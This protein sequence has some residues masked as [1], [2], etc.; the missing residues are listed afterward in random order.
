MSNPCNFGR[1]TDAR[2]TSL[3]VKS[4]TAIDE[5]C[6]FKGKGANFKELNVRD[7]ATI[8]GDLTIKGNLC[9]DNGC[10]SSGVICETQ[11]DFCC[12]A[13]YVIVGAGAAGSVL[14]GRLAE[15]GYSVYLIEAG[16]DTSPTSKDLDAQPDL[17]NIQVPLNFLNLYNR[18]NEI[19]PAGN[20]DGQW[21]ATSTLLDFV[22]IDQGNVPY[23]SYPRGAGAGGSVSHHALQDGVGSLKVYD[24]L[25]EETGDDFWR[26]SN[27][28]RLF[29][30]M[31]D[32][33]AVP[34]NPGPIFAGQ[35]GWLKLSQGTIEPI[36]ANIIEVVTAPPFNVPFRE[37]FKNPANVSGIGNADIQVNPQGLR[38]QPYDGFLVPIQQTTGR[39]ITKFNHLASKLLLTENCDGGYKCTGV[40]AFD[41]RFAQEI[42]TGGATFGNI[43]GS[44]TVIPSDKTKPAKYTKFYAKKEVIV[45]GGAIQSP[46]LLMLSGIGP[47]DHLD[48]VGIE[49]KVD[50][51]GVGSNLTDHCEFSAIFE[52]DPTKYIHGWQAALLLGDNNGDDI[53]DPNI[54]AVAQASADAGQFNE[55][56]G[57]IAWDWHS[58]FEAIDPLFPDTHSIPYATFFWTFDN[59]LLPNTPLDP[60]HPSEHNDHNRRTLLP[61]PSNPTSTTAGPNNK[62]VL[63]SSQFNPAA[64][65]VFLTWLVENLKPVTVNGTIRLRSNDPCREPIIDERLYEDDGG[66]ERMARKFLQVRD[67]MNTSQIFDNFAIGSEWEIT[68][69]NAAVTV[70]DVKTVIKNW[71]AY[72]HH[73]SGTCQMGPDDDDNAVVDSRLRVKGVDGLRVCDTSVY[74]APNL[75][76]YNTSRAAYVMAEALAERIIQNI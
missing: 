68:P 47:A 9:V 46:Q 7:S 44:C 19:D 4:K 71:S 64:P 5:N 26:G 54:K 17:P 67:V 35:D 59:D 36:H 28:D 76:A 38:S 39:I 75:H 12:E 62:A 37:N 55:N 15:A 14:A 11:G 24:I 72:G 18:Y 58:G 61:D 31:E 22:S 65:R 45:C 33:T 29:K 41:K 51:P 73:I 34:S 56:T 2:V 27:M 70:E 52:L 21:H 69:G 16:P 8:C 60:L 23:Y 20:C 32:Y 3:C 66:I 48:S 74:R 53:V 30:K 6:N 43:E 40:E 42:H 10:G 13:D 50:S 49:T 25:A 57:P 1:V 63:V